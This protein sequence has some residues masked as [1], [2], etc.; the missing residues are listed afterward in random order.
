MPFTPAHTAILLPARWLN[1]KYISWTALII[2]SMVP[3]VEYFIWMNSGSYISH[4]FWGILVFN[5]PMTFLIAFAWHSFIGKN[6]LQKL[7]FLKSKY[8]TSTIY[9]FADWFRRNYVVFIISAIV[10]IMS[11]LF[12]D[13]FCH[14]KGFMVKRIPILID[15]AHIAGHNIRWCYVLWYVCTLIGLATV[16]LIIIDRK[17]LLDMKQWRLLSKYR[18]YWGKVFLTALILSTARVVLG[19]NQNVPRHLI[20]IAIG[21]F[22][23]GI[24]INSF[25]E[26]NNKIII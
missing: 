2:G 9:D 20:I 6:L 25:L 26:R 8:K 16:L 24:I 10:G 1:P 12:W 13:S 4:S 7:P 17:A 22:L 15:Y 5:L 18:N 19:L 11:H 21:S 14:S 3:D 23:Y